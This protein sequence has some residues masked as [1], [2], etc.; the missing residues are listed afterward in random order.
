MAK[1]LMTRTQLARHFGITVAALKDQLSNIGILTHDGKAP[2]LAPHLDSTVA[3]RNMADNPAER[4]FLLDR[5]AIEQVLPELAKDA[6]QR[7][8][9]NIY[10]KHKAGDLLQGA[11]YTLLS[12][13]S[14]K[15]LKSCAYG[16]EEIGWL[17][18]KSGIN[19]VTTRD[20]EAEIRFAE[21]L[22]RILEVIRQDIKSR[23]ISSKGEGVSQALDTI[24]AV[25]DWYRNR[26]KRKPKLRLPDRAVK[27]P[28]V[29]VYSE[30]A[31]RFAAG[32]NPLSI[33][34][35]PN[36]ATLLEN[37]YTFST[38]GAVTGLAANALRDAVTAAIAANGDD[39]ERLGTTPPHWFRISGD[40]RVLL[41]A[42]TDECLALGECLW[43]WAFEVDLANGIL[44]IGS[45]THDPDYNLQA[46]RLAS[47]YEC[48]LV[49]LG[50]PKT[51]RH[52]EMASQ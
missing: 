2:A 18:Y 30:E 4:Y 9:V 17:C 16:T 6:E 22:E 35:T 5:E 21:R 46:E 19:A 42:V 49:D 51:I 38:S 52:I 28:T 47:D 20:R 8:A 1:R 11:G 27:S 14:Q 31:R 50:K 37:G 32:N 40:K 29:L 33:S 23:K 7:R 45:P 36:E 26:R 48:D 39:L 13:V 10:H 44:T 15:Q 12:A 43:W 34:L 24:S 3:W 41:A 25:A